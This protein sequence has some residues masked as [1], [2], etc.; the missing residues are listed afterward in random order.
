[1]N[2]ARKQACSG[3]MTVMKTSMHPRVPW[4]SCTRPSTCCGAPSTGR[5]G[6][7]GDKDARQRRA[8]GHQ[9]RRLDG[10][11]VSRSHEG[12]QNTPM[13]RTI[14]IALLFALPAEAAKYALRGTVVTPEDVIVNGIVVVDGNT[15]ADVV[16]T[17]PAGMTVID[18]GGLIFPG[19]IDLHNHVTWNAFPRWRA[20]RAVTARY[21]WLADP[22]YL[23]TLNAPHGQVVKTN[24]CDLERYGEVK[25][26]VNGAT[27]IAGSL[28]DPCDKG[29]IR[30]ID[31]DPG[32]AGKAPAQYRVFP[33]ELDA[34]KDTEGI[35]R[36]ALADG[37]N[38]IIHLAE[39]VTESTRRELN[40]LKAHGFMTRGLITI[41]GV[42]LNA[43]DFVALKKAEVGLVWSPRSNLELYG[44]TVDLKAALGAQLSIAISPDWSPSGSAGMIPEMTYAWRWLEDVDTP[45]TAKN[46]VEMATVNP[47]ALI[48][49]KTGRIEK[50]YA[51]DL[52][53][54]ARQ[55]RGESYETL[56]ETEPAGVKLVVVGGKPLYGDAALL[57]KVNPAAK[58][59]PITVC[60]AAKVIDMSD[61]DDGKGITWAATRANLSAAMSK[62]S[63]PVALAE[64]V[65]CR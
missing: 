62:L 18:T 15:I 60:G 55:S 51:A 46:I 65:D 37:T 31:Y 3:S 38:V 13:R 64:L 56:L 14:L 44:T 58:T 61:S 42:A 1:M 40:M 21:D 50:G 53:V 43:N 63:P 54:V 10:D 29:L 57:A 8:A 24:P 26:M 25:A 22:D 28:D 30:N 7:V 39:G 17:P 2:P 34:A 35:V 32:F 33:F 49:D 11:F 48:G 9:F 20:K 6:H 4:R 16:T 41:H 12:E 23:A 45:L 52:L 47:A 36:K 5:D 27:A 59:E 19:L